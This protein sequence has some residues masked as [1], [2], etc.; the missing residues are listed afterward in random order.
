MLY[1]NYTSIKKIH[2]MDSLRAMRKDITLVNFTNLTL[3]WSSQIGKSTS[4][5][6]IYICKIMIYDICDI[7]KLCIHITCT[8]HVYI[9][10]HL[11]YNVKIIMIRSQVVAIILCINWVCRGFSDD[12]HSLHPD[13]NAG[14]IQFS[15]VQ[16]LSHVWLFA[17][18]WVTL[19]EFSFWKFIE[20]TLILNI[21]T[22]KK[23]RK[24]VEHIYLLS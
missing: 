12:C 8:L 4:F 1:V 20:L 11:M 16:S 5:M 6:T 17:T 21:P 9:H 10:I 14:S 3:N 18:P 15:S 23:Q 7:E 2:T 13:L 19:G 24:F 22:P